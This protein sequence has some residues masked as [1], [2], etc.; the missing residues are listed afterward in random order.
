M[1]GKGE[2]VLAIHSPARLFADKQESLPG[3]TY[4][5]TLHGRMEGGR[6]RYDTVSAERLFAARP[7]TAEGK[8]DLRILRKNAEER[9]TRE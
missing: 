6:P 1:T 7:M 9:L 2:V 8:T 5:F 3:R 4:W